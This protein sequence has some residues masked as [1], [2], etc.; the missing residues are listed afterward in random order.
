MKYNNNWLINI[1]N[2]QT[3]LKFLFFWGHHPGKDGHPSKNCLSQWWVAPFE[4]DGIMYKTAEHWMMACKAR[5]FNDEGV[6]QQII[7]AATPGEAKEKGR[8]VSGF[9]PVIWDKEK[10]NIV[11]TGN[12]HKFS[13]NQELATF[14]LNTGRRV[15]AEASPVDSIWGIGLAADDPCIHDPQ[16]WKGENLLGYALMEVRDRLK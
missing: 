13:K 8:A 16:K 4:V 14:L 2:E 10:I 1:S 7:A 11:V 9:D 6:F 15:I 5:L 12:L 3:P